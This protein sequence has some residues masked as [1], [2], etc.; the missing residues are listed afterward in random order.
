MNAV[1]SVATSATAMFSTPAN[2]VL[3]N[4][5]ANNVFIGLAGVSNTN[6]WLLAPGATRRWRT[7]GKDDIYGIAETGATN[8]S[9]VKL[10]PGETFI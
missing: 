4:L 3:T 8:V 7:R 2:V 1:I 5:G 10:Q 6:G 9:V